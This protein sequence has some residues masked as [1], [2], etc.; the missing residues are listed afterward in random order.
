[1]PLVQADL[2]HI[3]NLVF[4]I[5]C[6]ISFF[7]ISVGVSQRYCTDTPPNAPHMSILSRVQTRIISSFYIYNT[8]FSRLFHVDKPW[9]SLARLTLGGRI[10][11]TPLFPQELFVS[12]G[13]NLLGA[14]CWCATGAPCGFSVW[15]R[16][17]VESSHG[18]SRRT[19]VSEGKHCRDSTC[20]QG[21]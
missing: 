3:W 14:A 2:F 6:L 11:D 7:S 18:S 21:I 5:V 9:E 17:E 20:R 10:S 4:R 12:Y 13:L 8:D 19:A 15:S 1:M 16:W